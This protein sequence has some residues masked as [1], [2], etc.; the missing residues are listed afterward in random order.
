LAG[1]TLLAVLLLAAGA[2][3]FTEALLGTPAQGGGQ[4]LTWRV[5][6]V[7]ALVIA[8]KV[9]AFVQR[10]RLKALHKAGQALHPAVWLLNLLGFV[11]LFVGLGTHLY[12]LTLFYEGPPAF[13]EDES[14]RLA[15]AAAAAPWALLSG[16]I[17]VVGTGVLTAG[18]WGSL[19]GVRTDT[20]AP[21]LNEPQR[22]S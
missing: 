19:R 6:L 14:A 1:L 3:S 18:V 16:S 11:L 7:F 17:M 4:L 10:A 8:L 5:G 12:G 9:L 20:R 22:G 21:G 13:M 15:R 2:L